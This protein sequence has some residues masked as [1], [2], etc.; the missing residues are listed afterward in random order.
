MAVIGTLILL[1]ISGQEWTVGSAFLWWLSGCSFVLALGWLFGW[2]VRRAFRGIATPLGNVMEAADAVA[3]GNL[4]IR[5]PERGTPEFRQLARSFNRMVTELER[6][7]EQRRNLTADVAHELRTPLHIIQGNLEGVLDGVYEPTPRTSRSYPDETR[8]LARLV[9]DLRLLS[10]AEAEQLT[11]TK[12]PVNVT[13]LLTD[14]QTSFSGAAETAGVSLQMEAES[15]L[16]VMADAGRLDQVIG[17]L[18]ANALRHTPH[19][20]RITLGA[21]SIPSGVRLTV[22]D[23]GEGIP[24]EALPFVFDRFW[25]GDRSRTRSEGGGSGLG[26]AIARQLVQAHGGRIEVESQP[27]MGTMFIIQLPD[28]I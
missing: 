22:S 2:G 24:P 9:E 6:S 7:D 11:L 13:E 19:G 25:K 3:D 27:G 15:G 21:E 4:R 10:L 20:G 1:F 8:A 23:T 12:E 18:I 14:V 17:N 28:E 5:V 16:T 26:L